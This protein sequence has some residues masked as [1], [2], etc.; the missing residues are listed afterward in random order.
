MATKN[1]KVLH[2]EKKGEIGR[3]NNEKDPDGKNKRAPRE[4]GIT[5]NEK[6]HSDRP[7][8]REIGITNNQNPRERKPENPEIG[9]VHNDLDEKKRS[10][11]KKPASR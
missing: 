2:L 7:V 5:N 11:K 4:I 9:V 10:E 1:E 8:E 6:S 3:I